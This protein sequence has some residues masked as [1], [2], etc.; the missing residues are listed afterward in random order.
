V[1][2]ANTTLTLHGYAAVVEKL[3]ADMKNEVPYRNLINVESVTLNDRQPD[4][5]ISMEMVPVATKD[6]FT[7]I[8]NGTLGTLSVVHGTA[9]GNIVELSAPTVQ[10][11]NPRFSDS[12]GICM[13]DTELVFAPGASGNDEI[14]IKVK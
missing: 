5:S 14:V 10:L 9:A 1:N 11:F 2:K 12:Q 4:G 6:W 13:L 3:Q 7:S 8:R